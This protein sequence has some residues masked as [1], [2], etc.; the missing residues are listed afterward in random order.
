MDLKTFDALTTR[1]G[2]ARVTRMTALRGLL[3]GALAG[4]TRAARAGVAIAQDFTGCPA[5]YWME[6][7]HFDSWTGYNPKTRL[8][9]SLMFRTPSTSRP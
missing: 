7:E 5:S 2:T 3:G 6:S 1:L 4:G 8:G 9:L